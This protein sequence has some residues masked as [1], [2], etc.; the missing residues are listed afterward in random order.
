[1]RKVYAFVHIEGESEKCL[2]ASSTI[3]PLDT[4]CSSMEG[5]QKKTRTSVLF[6]PKIKR[7][8]KKDTPFKYLT[9]GMFIKK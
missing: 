1:M 5:K 8:L 2:S 4:V 9:D 6:T 7:V 3:L